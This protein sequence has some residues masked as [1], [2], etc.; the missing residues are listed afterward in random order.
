MAGLTDSL[1]IIITANGSAAEREFA[2]VGA[3]SRRSLGM[4]E[5]NAQRYSRTLTSAGVAMAS[6]GAVALV[7]LGKAAQAAE[8]E[9]AALLRLENS[10]QNMPELA[11]AT[12][13]AFLEQAAALQDSTRFADDA[14]VSAQ[15]ML[16]TFHLTEQ[17]ILD[18]IPAVQDYAAK[19]GVDLVTAS[20]QVGR[21][22]SGSAGALQRNGIV[23]D[24][25]AFA[26]DHYGTVLSALRENAG[27]FAEQ[28]G[29]T[30]SGQ[31]EILKNNMMDLVEAVGGGAA[32]AFS[33]LMGP[34]NKL[35][36]AVQGLNPE[37][38][39]LIGRWATF[40]A[41][42]LTAAG[43]LSFVGGQALKLVD[44]FK[45]AGDSAIVLRARLALLN[46]GGAGFAG[47][48]AGAVLAGFAIAEYSRAQ[49]QA[50]REQNFA[51]ALKREAEGF[52]DATEQALAH[53]LATDDAI[54]NYRDLGISADTIVGAIKGEAGAWEELQQA[55]SDAEAVM[56]D[57]DLHNPAIE[58]QAFDIKEL[59]RN[60]GLQR[61]AYG[62]ANDA[63]NEF[64]AALRATG[65]AAQDT[66][67][68][69][70]DLTQ[71]ISDYLSGLFDVPGA[72]RDLQQSM[73][74][75]SETMTNGESSWFDM[76]EGQEEV[77][78]KTGDLIGAMIEQGA[79]QEEL[80]GAI[81]GSIASLAEMRDQGIITQG[82][83]ALLSGEIR[84]VP[85]Q[86][87]TP[88]SAPGLDTTYGTATNYRAMMDRI[89]GDTVRSSFVADGLDRIY[90]T[91]INYRAIMN[92]LDGYRATS[93]VNIVTSG[94]A[95]LSARGGPLG[96]GE[97]S[98]VGEKGPELF[99]P[100]TG[101][102]ILPAENTARLL[103]GMGRRGEGGGGT[104]IHV[105]VNGTATKADGQAVV[106]ALQRWSRSNGRVPV[107][108]MA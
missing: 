48:A 24:E 57:N 49:Q 83:F 26:A 29:Q 68:S 21:A 37:T 20:K 56:N 15:A 23:M 53:V 45:T 60:V 41:V 39:D 85:H 98:V 96:S 14:T 28:E 90:G 103:M 8:E 89:D 17:Q 46:V 33:T 6:F 30:L 72:Q 51:D 11:G 36:E 7:G 79:T 44:K 38:Q 55:R 77:V 94:S 81:Y 61:D 73:A 59:V 80:D 31:L 74:D 105:H 87:V 106:D 34:V 64:E 42:G 84:N 32:G 95:K 25:A 54:N 16:G 27:G 58:Q 22:V 50:A 13:D 19:F 76:A 66:A 92:D 10:I 65:G 107:K 40:G 62:Q 71:E 12:T 93:Y 104:S 5:N 88:V 86:S 18:L 108:T 4:A 99:V 43:A 97:M 2:K 70:E 82:A 67:Q 100:N 78:R 1:R 63:Q 101:G 75:L 69:I 91:A 35:S 102:N 9:H 47:V 52:A 3:A